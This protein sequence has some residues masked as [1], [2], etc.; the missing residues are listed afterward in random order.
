MKRTVKKSLAFLLSILMMLALIPPFTVSVSATDMHTEIIFTVTN[1]E[2]VFTITRSDSSIAQ[3]VYYRTVSKT[4]LA[5]VHFAAANGTLTFAVGETE[6]TVSVSE[7][8]PQNVSAV[9]RYQIYENRRCYE[10]EVYNSINQVLAYCERTLSGYEANIDTRYQ[11]VYIG[12]FSPELRLADASKIGEPQ[13]FDDLN[14]SHTSIRSYIKDLDVYRGLHVISGSNTYTVT[15]NGFDESELFNVSTSPLFVKAGFPQEY[16]AAVGAKIYMKPFIE[17]HEINDGYQYIQILLDNRSTCDDNASDGNPGTINNSFY[18]CGFEHDLNSSTYYSFPYNPNNDGLYETY[19]TNSCNFCTQK[20]NSAYGS[21]DETANALVFSPSV[22]E[23]TFRFDASGKDNDDWVISALKVRAFVAKTNPL[24]IINYKVCDGNYRNGQ[25]I[26]VAVQFDGVVTEAPSKI[27]T[28][29]GTLTSEGINGTNVIV[30]SGSVNGT[31]NSSFRILSFADGEYVCDLFNIRS[32]PSC[33]IFN[34]P[35]AK[36]VALE[37]PEYVNGAYQITNVTELIYFCN[38]ANSHPTANAVIMNDINCNPDGRDNLRLAIGTNSD[39]YQGTFSGNGNS[40][41]NGLAITNGFFKKI[42]HS[43][44][45]RDLKIAPKSVTL[46]NGRNGFLCAENY[47]LIERCSYVGSI[48]YIAMDNEQSVGVFAGVNYGT[49]RDCS[50]N[51]YFYVGGENYS[52]IVYE[53]FGTVKSC[54]SCGSTIFYV[55]NDA[56]ICVYNRSGGTIDNC[57]GF[58]NR[59]VVSLCYVNEGTVTRCEIKEERHFNTGEVAWL[60]NEG[61]TD[62]TQVWYQNLECGAL[63]DAVPQYTGGTVYKHGNIYT[64]SLVHTPVLVPEVQADCTHDGCAAHYVCTF[65][66]CGKIFTD[67]GGQNE[68]T[69]EA[70]TIPAL[71]HVMSESYNHNSTHHWQNCSRCNAMSETE[72]HSYTEATQWRWNNYESPTFKLNCSV[73][74]AQYEFTADAT[75]TQTANDITFTAETTVNGTTYSNV[76]TLPKLAVGENTVQ[77]TQQQFTTYFFVPSED[78]RFVFYST[79]NYNP[80]I[81]IYDL[82]GTMLANSDDISSSD[83]NFKLSID[84]EGGTPYCIKLYS[85]EDTATLSMIIRSQ[86]DINGDGL[87]NVTDIGYI[88]SASVG[89][90]TMTAQQEIAADLNGDGAVDAFDAAELERCLYSINTAKGDVNQDGNTDLADY[91]MTKAYI[92]GTAVDANTPA[93]LLSTDYLDSRY[94]TLKTQYPEGTII[95]QQYYCADYDGDKAVDAFDLFYLD[96]RINNIA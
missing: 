32:T 21:I 39:G 57:Y 89:G 55:V 4:A 17:M 90:I 56:I 45:V 65:D 88:L 29:F 34:S 66:N 71:G 10:F 8:N 25:P 2:N 73:C 12:T 87:K 26:S 38:Y 49:V 7:Y 61:V 30:Y 92:S 67:A 37:T 5:G 44:V 41:L 33:T 24:K 95:T 86:Y 27:Y 70:L 50:T 15:D 52:C 74:G 82:S 68:T 75:Y 35:N 83:R 36:I 23:I 63:S 60:L 46:L 81:D 18:M 40:T 96:K 13:A 84:L 93:N 47:G 80:S 6:K 43:G 64:N 20:V 19:D 94:D 91:A 62:G 28:S 78:E 9:N 22:N 77:V 76:K 59:C 14:D 54:V 1:N 16:L 3:T 31:V 85:M 69:L 79:G 48:S 11:M 51:G 53:N 72:A 42:G 58:N